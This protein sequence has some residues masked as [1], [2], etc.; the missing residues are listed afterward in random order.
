MSLYTDSMEEATYW[1][2]EED[3]REE[4]SFLKDRVTPG[5]EYKLVLLKQK[6]TN[7]KGEE[8]QDE[9]YFIKDDKGQWGMHYMV[10]KGYFIK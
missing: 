4:R 1:V 8:I 7:I 2:A 5:K 9:E 6:M 3:G 10:H